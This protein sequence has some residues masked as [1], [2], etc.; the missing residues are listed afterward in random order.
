MANACPPVACMLRSFRHRCHRL[1]SNFR[2]Q[3]VL[4]D[5]DQVMTNRYPISNKAHAFCGWNKHA[6]PFGKRL[7]NKSIRRIERERLATSAR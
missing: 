5:C 7:A 3:W 1:R 4:K 2:S 6:R